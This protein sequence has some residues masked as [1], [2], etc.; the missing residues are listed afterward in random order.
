MFDVYEMWKKSMLFSLGAV[1][2]S[3]EEAGKIIDDFIKKGTEA[4]E[5]SEDVFKEFREKVT[6][7]GGDFE[8]KVETQVAKTIKKMDIPTKKDIEDLKKKL[9]TIAAKIKA[10]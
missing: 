2:Y 1:A 5:K 3:V 7:E 8:K 9:D 10:D 4:V 6:K